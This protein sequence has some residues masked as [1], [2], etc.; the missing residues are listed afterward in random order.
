MRSASRTAVWAGSVIDG[1]RLGQLICRLRR[2]ALL[3]HKRP[4]RFVH[5]LTPGLRDVDTLIELARALVRGRIFHRDPFDNNDRPDTTAREQA[6]YLTEREL[7]SDLFFFNTA[8]AG[9]NE[10]LG[11]FGLDDDGSGLKLTYAENAPLHEWPVF[12]RAVK[13]MSILSKHMNSQPKEVVLLPFFKD[14]GRVTVVHPLGGCRIGANKSEGTVDTLGRIY[15]GDAA[16]DTTDVLPGVYVVD[17]AGT[18]N[19]DNANPANPNVLEYIGASQRRL[20][21]ELG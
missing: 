8:G 1:V 14:D 3:L 15:D 17:V 18:A 5:A 4:E 2:A 6:A 19:S 9:P 10:P 21:N 16:D 20:V 7:L 13:T 11:T 12:E